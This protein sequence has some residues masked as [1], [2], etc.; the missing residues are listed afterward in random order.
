MT[1]HL[2]G[3]KIMTEQN[4]GFINEAKLDFKDISSEK[5]REY[6]YL[7]LVVIECIHLKDGVT[8]SNR[9]KVGQ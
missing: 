4:E 3:D 2:K 6:M 7:N 5:E 1:G 9:E 8:T